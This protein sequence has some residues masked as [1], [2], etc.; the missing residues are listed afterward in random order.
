M[1]LLRQLVS[2]AILIPFACHAA[3]SVS[4]RLVGDDSG[5]SAQVTS[6]IETTLKRLGP[7]VRLELE[8][9]IPGQHRLLIAVGVKAARSV[10]SSSADPVLAVLPPGH[11][12]DFGGGGDRAI[13]VIYGDMP[14]GRLLNFAQLIQGKK[15]G[16]VGLIAGPVTLSRIARLEAAAGE[17]AMRLHVEKIEREN[18]AGPAVERVVRDSSVLLALPD[19]IAHTAGTVPPLLL[20]TY[21]AGVPVIG[22]SDAYLRAGAVAVLYS[23]PEQIAQQVSDVVSAF[24]LGKGLPAPQ[25]LK[26]FSVGVNHSVA[27]SLGLSLPSPLELESKLKGM[28]E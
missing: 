6:R 10:E 1:S 11:S 15:G 5:F 14:A 3:E 9:S 17:R 12:S 18:D 24:R 27:R 2:L 25:Y 21:W 19:P 8:P 26:Y 13:T 16:A 4:V 28:R 22:Y 23:S 7:D 20:I